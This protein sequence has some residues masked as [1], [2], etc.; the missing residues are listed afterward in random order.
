MYL[1][2]KNYCKKCHILRIVYIPA[3]T[4]IAWEFLIIQRLNYILA[5]TVLA[6]MYLRK[7]LRLVSQR[8][9]GGGYQ[10]YIHMIQ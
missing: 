2:K 7:Y 10:V 5:A 8:N 6:R 9:V 1:I 3:S 4:V